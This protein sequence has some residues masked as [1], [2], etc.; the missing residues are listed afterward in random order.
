MGCPFGT[1]ML[2]LM[3]ALLHTVMQVVL[4]HLPRV[5]VEIQLDSLLTGLGMGPGTELHAPGERAQRR[6]LFTKHCT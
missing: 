2:F 4:R 3:V 6:P 1:S 5:G